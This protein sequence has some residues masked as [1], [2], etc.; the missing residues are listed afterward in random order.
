MRIYSD[1]IEVLEVCPPPSNLKVH[2]DV[3]A[4]LRTEEV[5]SMASRFASFW[6]S[7]SERLQSLSRNTSPLENQEEAQKTL[8]DYRRRSDYERQQMMRMLLET[9]KEY[10]RSSGL[11]LTSVRRAMQEKV[12]DWDAE[13]ASFEHKFL[14]SER[15]LRRLTGGQFK[16]FFDSSSAPSTPDPR[17]SSPILAVEESERDSGD[18]SVQPSS[19]LS[20][21]DLPGGMPLSAAHL[22]AVDM[23]L[24]DL[25]KSSGA[26][27]APMP[28]SLSAPSLPPVQG[29]ASPRSA[30]PVSSTSHT[31]QAT[32]DAVQQEDTNASDSDS[33]VCADG[34]EVSNREHREE[35]EEADVVFSHPDGSG[36]ATL[37][38]ESV[39][40]PCDGQ[41]QP[42]TVAQAQPAQSGSTEENTHVAELV[43]KFDLSPAPSQSAKMPNLLDDR[44]LQVPKVPDAPRPPFKRGHSEYVKRLAQ[45]A[46]SSLGSSGA[47]TDPE[48]AAPQMSDSAGGASDNPSPRSSS[49]RVRKP[50]NLGVTRIPA[51][52]VKPAHSS[53]IKSEDDERD[54]RK[55]RSR[56][57]AVVS[58]KVSR[59]TAQSPSRSAFADASSPRRS[60]KPPPASHGR[61][62]EKAHPQRTLGQRRVATA[63]SGNRVSALA[64]HFDRLSQE[65]ERERQ[66]RMAALRGKRA[67]PVGVSK[68]VIEVYASAREA[69][70][71]DSDAEDE[72]DEDDE[73]TGA[74]DEFDEDDFVSSSKDVPRSGEHM[75]YHV[76]QRP[77]LSTSLPDS[78]QGDGT[79]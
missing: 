53:A 61:P 2:E 45:H 9:H 34:G 72:A 3:Q 16:R 36:N 69:L 63:N 73:G 25:P 38:K 1:P 49:H 20:I 41:P 71:E 68:A 40:G 23:Q 79:V 33:T 66:K 64:N 57:Q 32:K 13:L 29:S 22:A 44:D 60:L 50:R 12:V 8:E 42:S 55:S 11:A 46:N 4:R 28:R 65:A 17:L 59:S 74:D 56:K 37:P 54:H 19:L 58:R 24:G 51:R 27:A 52:P 7:L 48:H 14:P 62:S 6:N 10:T 76:Y 15:D 35:T 75:Q 47:L 78:P 43:K 30:H 70:Q 18:D 21:P 67:R 39:T 31:P 26:S 77:M 5:R